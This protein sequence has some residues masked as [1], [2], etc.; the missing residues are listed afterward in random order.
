MF[1]QQTQLAAMHMLTY[2]LLLLQAFAGGGAVSVTSGSTAFLSNVTM[3]GN[4]ASEQGAGALQTR[5]TQLVKLTGVLLSSNKVRF[6]LQIC[7]KSNITLQQW[8]ESAYADCCPD[9]AIFVRLCRA[10][11][12]ISVVGAKPMC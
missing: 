12:A 10:Q 8:Q 7:P 1:A 11:Q 2:W 5:F 6:W 4:S 3:R 9:A